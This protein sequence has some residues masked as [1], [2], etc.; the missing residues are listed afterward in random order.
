MQINSVTLLTLGK[1]EMRKKRAEA[2]SITSKCIL[3]SS[4][5][6]LGTWRFQGWYCI[7]CLACFARKARCLFSDLWCVRVCEIMGPVN[8]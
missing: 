1:Q 6:A 7:A 8:S 5:L 4:R 3:L 2:E